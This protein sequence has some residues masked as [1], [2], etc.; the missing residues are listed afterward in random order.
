MSALVVHAGEKTAEWVALIRSAA[1]ELQVFAWNERFDPDSI[2]YVVG[3]RPP[4][5]FFAP[6]A[7][8]KAVFATGAGIERLLAREDLCTSIP[9]VKLSDAGMAGR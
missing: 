5:N 6:L 8:L 2:D 1:P 4:E 3:S 9:I 7:Q